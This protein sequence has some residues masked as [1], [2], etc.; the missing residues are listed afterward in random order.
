MKE[1]FKERL[2]N[3]I[4]VFI[5]F[6]CLTF[7]WLLSDY[8]WISII[9]GLFIYFRFGT[10]YYYFVFTESELEIIYPLIPKRSLKMDFKDVD[11]LYHI[12]LYSGTFARRRSDLIRVVVA[13]KKYQVAIQREPED[14]RKINE[15]IHSSNWR[16]K[17]KTKGD[18]AHIKEIIKRREEGWIK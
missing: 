3:R 16:N 15:L 5:L 4:E 1:V 7:M 9:V 6:G 11:E 2:D 18:E 12:I 8:P 13:S 17:L 14:F 10:R